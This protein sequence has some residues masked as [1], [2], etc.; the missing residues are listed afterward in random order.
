MDILD[1]INALTNNEVERSTM[2]KPW[3]N[4]R[5]FFGSMASFNRELGV[6]EGQSEP[7]KVRSLLKENSPLPDGTL[8]D[9]GVENGAILNAV[10]GALAAGREG[11][12]K[13]GMLHGNLNGKTK[14]FLEK[15]IW[16][17][18]DLMDSAVKV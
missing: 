13:S 6:P 11:F 1:L 12:V 18:L 3:E 9:A 5:T 10:I 17:N 16:T 2:Q 14:V 4:S 7:S 8:E 15:D